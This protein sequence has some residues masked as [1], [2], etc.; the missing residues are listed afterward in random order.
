[1]GPFAIVVGGLTIEPPIDPF[2]PPF[3]ESR[4]ED[5]MDGLFIEEGTG[6]VGC[7]MAAMIFNIID[8]C[9]EDHRFFVYKISYKESRN[10]TLLY[11]L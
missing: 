3:I 11:V 4:G 6:R 5:K 9:S 1:M 10:S 8:W 7:L 2:I